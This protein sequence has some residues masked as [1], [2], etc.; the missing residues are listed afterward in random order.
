[1][2][3]DSQT[4][5]ILVKNLKFSNLNIHRLESDIELSAKAVGF[6]QI[7]KSADNPKALKPLIVKN[8]RDL[9]RDLDKKHNSGEDD[10]LDAYR[11]YYSFSS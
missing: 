6:M 2:Y 7:L 8:L 4:K 1:M 3:L 5:Q 10:L 9:K 11:N